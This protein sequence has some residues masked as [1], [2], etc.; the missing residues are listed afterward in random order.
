MKKINKLKLKNN[1][2]LKFAGEPRLSV[3]RVKAIKNVGICPLSY[4]FLKAKLVVKKGDRIQRGDALFFDKKNPQ[5]YFHSPVSGIIEEI[6][7]GPQR[8]LDLIEIKQTNEKA[9]LFNDLK[10]NDVDSVQFKSALLERGLWN[11][12]IELPFYNIPEPSKN[13][14]AIVV[15]L[16][17]SEPFQPKLSTAIDEYEKDIIEGIQWLKKLCPEIRLFVDADEQINL[18]NISEHSMITRV[19]GDFAATSAGSVAYH[20]KTS[21]EDN[22]AWI[23]NWQHLVKIARTLKTN[24]YYNETLI[25]IGGNQTDI[26]QH[27]IVTEGISFEEVFSIENQSDR[28]I[29]G[30]LFTGLHIFNPEYLPIGTTSINIID[31]N[32]QTEFLS[33]LQPG[34]EKP[35]Y[36]TAYLSGVISKLIPNYRTKTSTAVNGSDRDC[37]SCGYCELVC[38]VNTTPQTLLRNSKINDVEESMRI[39]LLD[40]SGCG[41]CTYVCPS[42]ID[43]ASTFIDM[44]NQLFKELNA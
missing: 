18:D 17:H 40:C 2:S 31:N 39:G 20:L 8:R 4:N 5:V 24:E 11:G 27:Y 42:K 15:P 37:V 29:C 28:V 10:L 1:F 16:S 14:P 26:N 13:P 43:L 23:C 9:T 22:N 21:V 35:S 6:K 41:A 30:G 19:S 36:S 33:F 25:C 3:K 12:F 7:Y 32:P 44:K 38:P 34:V